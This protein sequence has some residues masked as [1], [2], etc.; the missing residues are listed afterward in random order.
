MVGPGR[1]P[2]SGTRPLEGFSH[3]DDLL[4]SVDVINALTVTGLVVRGSGG[5]AGIVGDVHVWVGVV[6][7]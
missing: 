1:R 2:S 6:V 7:V 5:V 4:A 3:L